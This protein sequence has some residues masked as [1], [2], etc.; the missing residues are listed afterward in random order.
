MTITYKNNFQSNTPLQNLPKLAFWFE[1]KP[2][3]NPDTDQVNQLIALS[4]VA[5]MNRVYR[6]G[7][8]LWAKGIVELAVV[9][10]L[11]LNLSMFLHTNGPFFLFFY[12]PPKAPR[13]RR[14]LGMVGPFF[15]WDQ[16]PFSAFWRLQAGT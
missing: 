6:H 7:G 15:H 9:N 1:N 16:R 4:A 10:F 2:S 8:K 13:S 5:A 12:G 14:S 3:G 11:L